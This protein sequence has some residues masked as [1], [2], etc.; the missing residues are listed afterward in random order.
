MPTPDNTSA[1]ACA[2]DP[3]G[4]C[5][6]CRELIH[7]I[8]SAYITLT[9]EAMEKSQSFGKQCRPCMN[10]HVDYVMARIVRELVA[11]NPS[12]YRRQYAIGIITGF[13]N[14]AAVTPLLDYELRKLKDLEERPS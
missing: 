11:A 12:S 13:K 1:C 10:E 2:K 14:T 3:D 7:S 6:S 8:L 5:P 9:I 4:K